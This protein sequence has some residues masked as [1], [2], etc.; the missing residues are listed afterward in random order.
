MKS[1]Q[2]CFAIFYI[3]FYDSLSALNVIYPGCVGDYTKKSTLYGS[4]YTVVPPFGETLPII[5][6]QKDI[7][8][9]MISIFNIHLVL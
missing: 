4:Y 5:A 1:K 7:L 2:L 9:F 6:E 3:A 8:N